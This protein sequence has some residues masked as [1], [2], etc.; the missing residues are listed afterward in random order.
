[1]RPAATSDKEIQKVLRARFV[2]DWRL[3]TKNLGEG[4]T[5]KM[6]RRR[7][8]RVARDYAFQGGRRDDVYSPASPTHLLRM[9]PGLNLKRIGLFRGWRNSQQHFPWCPSAW[10]HWLPG[11]ISSSTPRRTSTITTWRFRT[12]GSKVSA[13]V[14]ELGVTTF[15]SIC[16]TSLRW[17]YARSAHVSPRTQR[18]QRLPHDNF[19]WKGLCVE[20]CWT[21]FLPKVKQ[22][23]NIMDKPGDKISLLK[24]KPCTLSAVHVFVKI[25]VFWQRLEGRNLDSS[26]VLK[27]TELWT[28]QD[29]HFGKTYASGTGSQNLNKL[30]VVQTSKNQWHQQNSGFAE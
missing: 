12:Y 15:P 9:L 29:H 6:W 19:W 16:R 14:L 22:K 30:D 3:A 17:S 25:I 20:P 26:D 8:R 27:K 10:G 23:F 21:H 5:V 1:M 24:Q 18:W 2:Y 4:K 7:W 13:L 11:R 28:R